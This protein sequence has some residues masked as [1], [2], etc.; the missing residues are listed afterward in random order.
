MKQ[1]NLLITLAL[2][3]VMTFL[4]SS[5]EE[6]KMA[7]LT[8]PT[9]ETVEET[10]L[11]ALQS[12]FTLPDEAKRWSEEQLKEYV[13]GVHNGEIPVARSHSNLDQASQCL[14]ELHSNPAAPFRIILG[15]TLYI[16]VVDNSVY[17][18]QNHL[19]NICSWDMLYR[20]GAFPYD[21]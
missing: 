18:S 4:L 21:D 20:V 10:D 6:E 14:A 16:V 5:C 12:L 3:V 1:F 9:P 17:F 2:L 8:T 19:N 15:N 7:D 11:P 13:R